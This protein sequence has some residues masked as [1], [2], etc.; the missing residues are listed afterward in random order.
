MT[1]EP[2]DAK[3]ELDAI[4]EDVELGQADPDDLL[5]RLA[6][7]LL[8]LQNDS[9]HRPRTHRLLSVVHRR[10]NLHRDALRELGEA[11]M[12][13]ESAEPPNYAELAKIG[14]ETATIYGRGGDD[15][16]AAAELLPALAF[17]S[18]EGDER[19]VAKIVAEFGRI[20]F[21]AQRFGNVVM[22]LRQLVS[23]GVNSKLSPRDLRRIRIDLCHALNR[24]GTYGEVLSH[25]S[26]LRSSLPKSEVR[27]QFLTRLEEARALGGL[28][29]FDDAERVLR[30]A[31]T[32]LPEKDSAFERS[33]FLQAVTEL[34]E[35]KGGLPAT[36][37][38]EHLIKEYAKQGERARE[39]VACRALASASL[40]RGESGPA[41]AAL[42]RALR[43]ALQSNLREMAEDIRADLATIAGT[44]HLEDLGQA[45]DL[46]GRANVGERRFVLL[47]RLGKGGAGELHRAIDLADGQLVALRKIDLGNLGEDRFPV[48]ANAIK[49][50]YAAAGQFNDPRL[51]GVLDLRMAPGGAVYIVQRFVEGQTLRQVYGSGAAPARLLGLLA[52]VAEALVVLHS[53]NIV[54]RDLKPANIIVARNAEGGEAPVI[55][56]LGIASVVGR[57]T[58][59]PISARRL[60]W[61]RSRRRVGRSMGRPMSTP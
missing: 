19:E 16:A 55:I 6:T 39:A 8:S 21:E 61:R 56:D 57:A 1:A 26:S 23:Q 50:A 4:E 52:G 3:P 37:S 41:R 43:T 32:L 29:R 51:A 33:E 7:L 46:I 13:A 20:E 36:K 59:A 53:Q 11:K 44:E 17:A 34:H 22:L 60:M 14:R 31:E 9:R 58:N 48:I 38:L 45:V 15:Q 12:L 35:V 10:R 47:D 40:K 2:Q 18:L 28:G 42:G 25:I 54:H 24:L 49:T 5:T 30:E 27:F